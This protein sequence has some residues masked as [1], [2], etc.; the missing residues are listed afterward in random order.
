MKVW[1]RFTQGNE[2]S[3]YEASVARFI[4]LHVYKQYESHYMLPFARVAMNVCMKVSGA[5]R[6]YCMHIY[7]VQRW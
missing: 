1:N 7:N 4:E 6:M 3:Q 5:Q 2:I